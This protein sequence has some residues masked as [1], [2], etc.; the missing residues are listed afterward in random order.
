FWQGHAQLEEQVA[1]V[2]VRLGIGRIRPERVGDAR[3]RLWHAAMQRQVGE[4]EMRARKAHNTMNHLIAQPE[5]AMVSEDQL[6]GDTRLHGKFPTG[7][8]VRRCTRWLSIR[9]IR[10]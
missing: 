1:Q 5:V 10:Y 6:T 3:A 4:Q 2:G 8:F 7:R 9:A